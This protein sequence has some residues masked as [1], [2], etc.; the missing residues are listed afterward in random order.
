[1]SECR[2]IRWQRDDRLKSYRVGM[3]G[4]DGMAS[5]S[6]HAHHGSCLGWLIVPITNRS[7]GF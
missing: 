1:M 6:C 4:F 7:L 5:Y 2:V 3:G